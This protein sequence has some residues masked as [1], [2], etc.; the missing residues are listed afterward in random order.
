MAVELICPMCDSPGRLI[1]KENV[2]GKIIFGAECT[3]PKCDF[4]IRPEWKFPAGA[5]HQWKA[6]SQYILNGEEEEKKKAPLS[7]R[8]TFPRKDGRYL[9]FLPNGGIIMRSVVKAG[10]RWMTAYGPLSNLPDGSLFYGPIPNPEFSEN[11]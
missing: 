6:S 4:A 1:K 7:W 5:Y 3:N 8:K 9:I 11:S 2:Y 10:K